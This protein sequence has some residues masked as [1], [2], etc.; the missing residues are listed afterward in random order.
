M[1]SC[2]FEHCRRLIQAL[3]FF[4]NPFYLAPVAYYIVAILLYYVYNSL[5]MY[6]GFAIDCGIMSF[7]ST[8]GR[9]RTRAL[10]RPLSMKR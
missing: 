10:T 1:L 2:E 4:L 8:S 9:T 7:G 5:N 3:F 6:P